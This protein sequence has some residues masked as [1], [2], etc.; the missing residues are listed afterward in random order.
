MSAKRAGHRAKRRG[1]ATRQPLVRLGTGQPVQEL[2]ELRRTPWPL[3][4]VATRSDVTVPERRGM[5]TPVGD[6]GPPSSVS[7]PIKLNRRCRIGLA[8]SKVVSIGHVSVVASG[9]GDATRHPRFPDERMQPIARHR[10]VLGEVV[11]RRAAHGAAKGVAEDEK[12]QAS[13]PAI[14]YCGAS[15]F[16]MACSPLRHWVYLCRLLRPGSAWSRPC[17]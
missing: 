9:F 10:V 15:Q 12:L 5:I 17:S 14:G 13:F 8:T 1:V 3:V 4:V 7:L 11:R 6:G 2:G 16:S